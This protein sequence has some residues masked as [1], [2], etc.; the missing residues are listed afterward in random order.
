MK[1]RVKDSANQKF[2]T[3]FD[4]FVLPRRKRSSINEDNGFSIAA[5]HSDKVHI[6]KINDHTIASCSRFF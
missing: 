6:E 1:K 5:V 3:P 2:L 4:L